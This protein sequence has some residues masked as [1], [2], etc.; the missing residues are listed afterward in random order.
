[1]N[2]SLCFL[3]SALAR[4]KQVMLH[5]GALGQVPVH[6]ALVVLLTSMMMRG[7]RDIVEVGD[8][9]TSRQVGERV[10]L[11]PGVPCWSNRMSRSA[12]HEVTVAI[13]QGHVPI[14][15]SRDMPGVWLYVL[16]VPELKL[17]FFCTVTAGKGGI[18]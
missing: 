16:F 8:G 15:D 17:V 13:T 18:T 6:W 12:W 5:R 4:L 9:V 7:C 14:H 11:E 3:C 10:A 2:S 1:M